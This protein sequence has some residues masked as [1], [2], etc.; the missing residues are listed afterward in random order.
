MATRYWVLGSG[1]WDA[2][3][4]TNWSATSGGTG[5]A[6]APTSADDVVFNNLSGAAPTVT[7]GTNATCGAVTITAPTSGTLTFVFSTTGVIS[8]NGNWSSPASLFATTGAGSIAAGAIRYVGSGSS[9][10]TTNGYSFTASFGVNTSAGTLTLGGA[11][12][13]ASSLIVT[14]GTFSTSA[15][16][17]SLTAAALSSSNSNTR[18]ISLNASTVTLTGSSP[19][20]LT[21]ATGLTFNA[22]TSTIT[23][24]S[25]TPTFAGGGQ[26]FN[27]VSFTF[28]SLNLTITGANTFAS[29]TT[30]SR[31]SD[32]INNISFAGN[33]TVTGTL[34]LGTS[35]TAVRRLFVQS[36]IFGST[37][38]LTVAT[39][40]TLSDVDFQDITISGAASPASGTRLGDCQG[41]TNI[42]FPAAKTVYWNLAG[43]QNWS[44][45]G[46]AT[47]SGG[48]P[49]VNNFPLAQ[50]TATFDNTGSVTGVITINAVW[51]IGTIDMSARTSAMTLA[52][53]SDAIIYGS[54]KN[55]TGTTLSGST[56]VLTFSGRSPTQQITSNSVLFNNPITVDNLTGTV[57]LVDDFTTGAT[58]TFTLTS[59]T[60]DL[61]GK[62]LST[63]LFSSSNSNTRTIAFGVGNI[64]CT[65]TGT[66]WTTTTVTN[67][68]ITGTPVVNVTSSGSTAITVNTGALSEANS[69]S[70]NFTGGNYALTFLNTNGQS[71]RSVD[72]TGYAG[73]W[74]ITGA[75]NIYGNFK[76]STGISLTASNSAITFG[77]TSGTQTITS[78]TKTMDF[79]IT[80]NGNS[81]TTVTCADALTL[82]S[83]RALTFSL[84]TLQLAAGVTN[85]VGSF[86]TSGTTLKYLQS[87]TSGTQATLSDA[88]GTNTVTYLSVQDSNATGGAT[89]VGTDATNVNAGNN[90][91]WSLPALIL[92]KGSFLMFF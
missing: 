44:A 87:T 13:T 81:A 55:G 61:N 89:F 38:T 20:T 52:I 79:P 24:S 19:I 86:V 30:S 47:S 62:K 12:T 5:G 32:G 25:S 77:A 72:F 67:L 83:S 22:G 56:G 39:I 34:T 68:T 73:T 31:T 8:Y 60:L 41:N 11:L 49:A 66:V 14:Q 84:G 59:G 88:S 82:G 42:T 27:S 69:I 37:T 29:L 58:R 78:N 35:N 43:A 6:S 51:N 4:T 36:A 9:T 50:D 64:T 15:S 40:A 26:T 90:T 23:C 74:G 75:V 53:N 63:G 71:A 46:W 76:L 21:T 28:S 85:T 70:Y 10:L 7:I 91:G 2:T 1:T 92:A 45:V 18:T 33:Q 3:T 65:G 54:W 16:N 80:I 48:T 57:Q 17:Y